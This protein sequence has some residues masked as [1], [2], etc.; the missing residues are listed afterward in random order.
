MHA[1]PAERAKSYGGHGRQGFALTRRHLHDLA[2]VQT[3]TAHH[4]HVEGTQPDLAPGHLPHE[5]KDIDEHVVQRSARPRVL[6][7]PLR[8][9]PQLRLA[10]SP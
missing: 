6:H 10:G 7:E 5:R 9:P 2:F 4:L 1:P 8:F 3:Q